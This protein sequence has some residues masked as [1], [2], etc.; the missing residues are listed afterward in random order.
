MSCRSTT[1]AQIVRPYSS[2]FGESVGFNGNSLKPRCGNATERRLALRQL[3]AYPIPSFIRKKLEFH[4]GETGVS[5][6]RN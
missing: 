1:D 4:A 2:R 5:Y 6:G 3:L